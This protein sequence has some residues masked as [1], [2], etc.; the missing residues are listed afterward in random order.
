MPTHVSA[1]L[2]QAWTD[3]HKI[4]MKEWK[5]TDG[6][7]WQYITSYKGLTLPNIGPSLVSMKSQS[8][9]N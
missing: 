1:E 7:L 6:T 8:Y 4:R 9:L 2:L 5:E 3:S